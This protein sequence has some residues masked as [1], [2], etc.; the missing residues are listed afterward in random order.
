[1]NAA[2]TVIRVLLTVVAC[3]C[4]MATAQGRDR[5]IETSISLGDSTGY[6][7]VA[8]ARHDENVSHSR[9][10]KNVEQGSA[11]T[12]VDSAPTS[13]EN[14]E[15]GSTEP[16]TN[17]LQADCNDGC[18]CS[19]L[20]LPYPSIYGQVDVLFLH[21]EPRFRRQAIVVDPNTDTTFLS[22]SDLDFDGDTGLRATIGTRICGGNALEF[23]YF[24]LP[25]GDADAFASSADPAAFLIFPDNLFGNVFVDAD[26]FGVNYSS[27]L[28]SFELNLLP[29]CGCCDQCC[30]DCSNQCG[31]G[32]VCYQSFEWFTGFRYVNIGEDLNIAAE[33]DIAGG[34]EQGNYDIRT[35]NHLY[36]VQVGMRERKTRGRFGYETTGKVGIF[37]NDAT[38]T[39]SVTDFP[40]FELRPTVSS[41]G[42]RVAFVGD[43]NI[44]GLYRLT[45]IWNLRA[46]YNLIWIEGLALAPDQLDFDFASATGGTRLHDG[47]GI[48]LHGVNVG[49]EAR[50]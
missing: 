30:N 13:P 11:L 2:A 3:N 29:C 8:S 21:R 33:R 37:G 44:S 19:C 42:G 7:L 32:E 23:T 6:D 40:D 39:Q 43:I 48:F 20:D 26:R 10:D 50:W 4:T 31:F 46:G 24:G 9:S 14:E 45:E 35:R 15:Q 12:A 49:V 27:S 38:Q 18:R 17:D 5:P 28:N 36:G 1:M 25:D 41:R 47:G 34:T 16:L 22:T